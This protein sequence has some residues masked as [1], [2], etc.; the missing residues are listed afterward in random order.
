[1][2]DLAAELGV[3]KKTI[4]LQFADKAMVIEKCLDYLLRAH[5]QRLDDA[6]SSTAGNAIDKVI[7]TSAFVFSH[8]R[9]MNPSVK[10]DLQKYYPGLWAKIDEFNNKTF[11]NFSCQIIKQG[12]DEGLF[13]SKVNVEMV[14]R[15]FTNSVDFLAC[16][17]HPFFANR[18]LGELL[19]GFVTYH[20]KGISTREG[21][22]YLES[23]SDNISA[24]AD[25]NE[26]I[27]I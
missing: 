9:A 7:E 21:L 13:E 12:I 26:M 2:D 22:K 20:L 3:S 10:Y 18:D 24:Y 4:Y 23:V 16:R 27:Y 14:A 1:M 25:E 19:K 6:I 5:S 17:R 15:L 8:E 11:F